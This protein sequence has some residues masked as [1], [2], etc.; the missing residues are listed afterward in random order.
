MKSI[1]FAG[2][3]GGRAMAFRGAIAIALGVP[4]ISGVWGKWESGPVRGLVIVFG[5]YAALE[6]IGALGAALG[7]RNRAILG[8]A[9][10]DGLAAG[11]LLFPDLGGLAFAYLLGAWAMATGIL[12]LFAAG[13][14][15]KSPPLVRAQAAAGGVSILLGLVLAFHPGIET[16]NLAGWLGATMV[17][18]GVLC[19]VAAGHVRADASGRVR[20]PRRNRRRAA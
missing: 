6:T 18:F 17:S 3:P 10:V 7:L 2:K 12:E 11:L 14:T 19:L 5:A 8:I 16:K 4:A 1:G 13:L 20:T 15:R 9:V